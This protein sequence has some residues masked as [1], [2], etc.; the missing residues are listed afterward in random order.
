MREGLLTPQPYGGA[1]VCK[2]SVV[3]YRKVQVKFVCGFCIHRILFS[4]HIK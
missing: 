4:S 1:L 3:G 2:V